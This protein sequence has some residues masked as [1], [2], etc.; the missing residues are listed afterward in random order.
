MNTTKSNLN[1]SVVFTFL[2]EYRAD[3]NHKEIFS[4]INQTQ[5]IKE[6]QEL[7]NFYKNDDGPADC[8][9]YTKT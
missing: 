9:G 1:Y 8:I 7:I 4:I 6:Q 2:D 3:D 5:V